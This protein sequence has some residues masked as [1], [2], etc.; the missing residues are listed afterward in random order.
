M[1]ATSCRGCEGCGQHLNAALDL[2]RSQ[3]A[4]WEPCGPSCPGYCHTDRCLYRQRYLEGSGVDGRWFRDHVQLAEDTSGQGSSEADH[5]LR[6]SSFAFT[7]LL[8]C[9]L[10]ETGLFRR[11]KPNGIL[12]LAPGSGLQPT[13]ISQ[14]LDSLQ[15]ADRNQYGQICRWS[16]SPRAFYWTFI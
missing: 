8:G 2:A 16:S 9:S 3:T 15:R 11:Q 12:G 14:I 7:A 13:L 6:R 4:V 5:S 1:S 10:S